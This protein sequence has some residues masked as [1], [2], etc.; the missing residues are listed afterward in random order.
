MVSPILR[1]LLLTPQAEQEKAGSR[2][3]NRWQRIHLGG[4]RPAGGNEV[5]DD[6]LVDIQIAL[7]LAEVANLVA[8]RKHAPDLRPKSKCVWQKLEYDV[9]IS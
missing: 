1:E 9:A 6:A 4:N 8:L 2:H 3:C 7:V 5:A